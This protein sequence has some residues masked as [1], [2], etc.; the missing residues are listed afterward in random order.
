MKSFP[1][2]GLL[3]LPA[4]IVRRLGLYAVN[5]LIVT[6]VGVFTIP[7]L[8]ASVGV[9]AWG[10][11]AVLQTIAQISLV[12][13][14][15]GWGV[16]GPSLVAAAPPDERT[17]LYSQSLRLRLALLIA[18]VPVAGALG[19]LF[20]GFENALLSFGA[21][22]GL[23][24]PG[25][26]AGWYFVG[27]ARPG[28]LLLLD[29]FP[30][31]TVSIAGLI[32]T[33]LSR[34]LWPYILS[35]GCGATLSAAISSFFILRDS[36]GLAPTTRVPFLIGIR[37]SLVSQR[38]AV[39]AS[40]VSTLYVSAPTLVIQ[41]FIPTKLPMYALMDRLYRYGAIA[42]GPVQQYLQGWIP[43]TNG[44][45]QERRRRMIL[46]VLIAGFLGIVGALILTCTGPLVAHI[47]SHGKIVLT[48]LDFLPLG[49]AFM[50]V[51]VSVTVGF[52]CLSVLGEVRVV[53][54]STMLGALLGVPL[55]VLAAASGDSIRLVAWALAVSEIAVSLFQG[56]VLWKRLR[57]TPAPT[58]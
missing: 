43:A 42:Y 38:H 52:A 39:L 6:A 48:P 51:C 3:T 11:F 18:V 15:Y 36:R 27:T 26:S 58:I 33:T 45:R 17:A 2:S 5:V 29:T 46:A 23:L 54:T 1:M 13:V 8:V 14:M 16:V 21:A 49:V 12:A 19:S 37:E 7:V 22:L 25:L 10:R 30:L 55:I 4:L 28:R 47:F 44:I 35:I 53:A 20:I 24:V 57:R 34:E 32:G 50:A 9:G 41:I 31:L 40:M 56:I